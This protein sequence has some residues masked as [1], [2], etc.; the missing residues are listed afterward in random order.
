MKNG[1]TV[2]TAIDGVGDGRAVVLS[3]LYTFRQGDEVGCMPTTM[4]KV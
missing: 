4:K 1:E 2:P 3:N